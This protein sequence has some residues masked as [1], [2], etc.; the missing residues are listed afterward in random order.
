M[1]PGSNSLNYT[2]WFTGGTF[3]TRS[4]LVHFRDACSQLII[5]NTGAFTSEP[6]RL[7]LKSGLI[8]ILPH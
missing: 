7:T 5:R 8:T 3:P 6:N 1:A 4:W 2:V